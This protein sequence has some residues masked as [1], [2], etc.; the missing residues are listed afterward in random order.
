MVTIEQLA[1]GTRVVWMGFMSLHTGVITD[2][3]G[4]KFDES[5]VTWG[6]KNVED[7][8]NNMTII[9]DERRRWNRD[10]EW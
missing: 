9:G 8:L 7:N 3:L 6:R 4:L 2:D 10:S 5:R 1:P